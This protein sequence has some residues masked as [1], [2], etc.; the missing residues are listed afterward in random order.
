M[1]NL[2]S[3]QRIIDIRPIE[4]A[5]NI[6]VCDILGWHVV[7]NK[8]DNFKIGDLVIYIEPDSILPV[9][10]EFEFLRD[11]KF[12]ISTIKLKKQISQGIVFPLSLL[13]SFGKLTYNNKGVPEKFWKP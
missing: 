7:I 1:R 11:R 9:I 8:K 13:E 5:D 10:A 12:R 4:G 6:L 2:A 3:V